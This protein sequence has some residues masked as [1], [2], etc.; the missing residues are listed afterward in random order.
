MIIIIS[1]IPII[2][3]SFSMSG[4][5]AGDPVFQDLWFS[6]GLKEVC[7]NTSGMPYILN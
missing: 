6:S 2:L 7:K 3:I 5:L 4:G 1:R